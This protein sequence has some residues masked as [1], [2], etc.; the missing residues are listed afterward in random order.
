[1]NNSVC[2][3]VCMY[4]IAEGVLKLSN[5][6]LLLLMSKIACFGGSYVLEMPN[7]EY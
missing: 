7:V 6:K 4:N 3:C 2:V 5:S 1:M